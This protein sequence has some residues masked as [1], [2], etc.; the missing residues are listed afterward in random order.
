M[1]SLKFKMEYLRRIYAR[2]HKASR[3]IKGEI[4]TELCRICRWHRKHALRA[5]ARPLDW[6]PRR[7]RPGRAPTYGPHAIAI[8]ADLWK[9]SG[10][11]CGQ[12]L[13]AA[14]PLWLPWAKKRYGL[15]A[16][17]EQQLRTISPRQMD[18]RLAPLKRRLKKRLYGTTKP[19]SLLKRMIPI[20]T[21]HWDVRRAGFQEIDLVSHSGPRAAGE[22]IYT[23]NATDI[24]TTW[25]ERQAVLGK[26][27]ANVVSGMGE[28]EHR[29]PFPL[30]GIDSVY[31]PPF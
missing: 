31:R 13:K 11:L 19:G 17:V 10:Y 18:R 15:A 9:A 2:Y 29:L 1:K 21:D 25:V 26:S 12:R 30:L 20:K 4:L 27:E 22:F 24:Q 6:R 23:L 8:L 7:R 28:I 3:V 16:H 14:L 5:L